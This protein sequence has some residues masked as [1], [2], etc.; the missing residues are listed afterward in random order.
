MVWDEDIRPVVLRHISY[1]HHNE[2]HM[3]GTSAQYHG[4][5]I[6]LKSL[7]SGS[8]CSLINHSYRRPVVNFKPK[9]SILLWVRNRATILSN[10]RKTKDGHISKKMPRHHKDLF[11]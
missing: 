1:H 5:F 3:E 6:N 4:S 7:N 10:V 11:Q 2:S 9:V 8:I